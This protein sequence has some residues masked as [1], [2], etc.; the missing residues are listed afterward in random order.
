MQIDREIEDKI[1]LVIN[2]CFFYYPLHWSTFIQRHSVNY[3]LF[4]WQKFWMLTMMKLEQV[5]YMDKLHLNY[6]IQ[7]ICWTVEHLYQ[8]YNF[9]TNS[10]WNSRLRIPKN[11]EDDQFSHIDRDRWWDGTGPILWNYF[12]YT[13]DIRRNFVHIMVY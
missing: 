4:N 13:P 11:D 7:T 8:T 5:V 1:K 9:L 6:R 3:R 2:C 10:K 12:L